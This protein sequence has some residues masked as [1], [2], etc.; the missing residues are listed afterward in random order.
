MFTATQQQ[1]LVDDC[2]QWRNELVSWRE[3]LQDLKNELYH[4]APGK[5]NHDITTGI[6]HFHNQLHLQLINIHDLKHEIKRHLAETE[7]YPTFGPRVAHR[8]LKDKVD[9][10]VSDLDKLENEFH[11]FIQP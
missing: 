1:S 11:T 3:R 10:L 2:H 5:T 4:F 8:I 9:M 7:R 6:E